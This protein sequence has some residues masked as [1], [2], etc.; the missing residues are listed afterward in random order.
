MTELFKLKKQSEQE[1]CNTCKKWGT[2][3]PVHEANIDTGKHTG[4]HY[5]MITETL[6]YVLVFPGSPL[7]IVIQVVCILAR[8]APPCSLQ[9]CTQVEQEPV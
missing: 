3:S 5:C 2:L 7:D 8:L 9:D 6:K 1:K 4:S